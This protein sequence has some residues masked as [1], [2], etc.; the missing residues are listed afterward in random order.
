ME[1]FLKQ[2]DLYVHMLQFS[3]SVQMAN[4][5]KNYLFNEVM[6]PFKKGALINQEKLV[7]HLNSLTKKKKTLRLNHSLA[8]TLLT[9]QEAR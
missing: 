1:S 2:R 8:A 6:F 9:N 3:M 7:P 5:S 4:K